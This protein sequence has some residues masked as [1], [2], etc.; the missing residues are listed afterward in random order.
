M[1]FLTLFAQEYASTEMVYAIPEVTKPEQA[2]Q[3][4]V[5]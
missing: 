5:W 1:S 4:V 3:V 2:G